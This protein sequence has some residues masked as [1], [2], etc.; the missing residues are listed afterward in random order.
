MNDETSPALPRALLVDLDDTILIDA[1]NAAAQWREVCERFAARFCDVPPALVL[2]TID[3]YRAWYWSDPERHRVGRQDLNVARTEAVAIALDR[4]GIDDPTLAAEMAAA[5]AALR[6]EAT[7]PF[8][9]ALETLH[10][11]RAAGV[12]L[13]LIT[14]GSAVS[15]RRKIERFGLAELFH[16]IVIEGEFGTGKPHESV[17]RHALAALGAQ[18]H[19]AWMV[20]DN[21]EWEVAAP[22]RLGIRGIWIDLAGTGL[23]TDSPVR[24]DRIIRSLAELLDP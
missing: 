16:C 11:L 13:A 14:N 7:L 4:V 5:Y 2:Q 15:Q 24:P 20:G 17:Y 3:D 10:R 22:Q 8:P 18:P 21:L 23:P 12:R 19:E 1:V 6:E 9:G